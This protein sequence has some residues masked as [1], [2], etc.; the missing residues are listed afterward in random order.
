MEGADLPAKQTPQTT[1]SN[2]R[3]HAYVT[4]NNEESDNVDSFNQDSALAEAIA[5]SSDVT[6]GEVESIIEEAIRQMDPKQPESNPQ[7]TRASHGQPPSEGATPKSE[8]LKKR[9]QPEP[10]QVVV[11]TASNDKIQSTEPR[12]SGD[13]A[14]TTGER[15]IKRAKMANKI[16]DAYKVSKPKN[17]R[18]QI[19]DKPTRPRPEGFTPAQDPANSKS[20]LPTSTAPSKAGASNSAADAKIPRAPQATFR[21]LYEPALGLTH[22][23]V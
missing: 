13:K 16:S 15:V 4:S 9:K 21:N 1:L 7:E 10:I 23:A 8:Q 19:N 3:R 18:T 17:D 12:P 2:K 6:Q 11:E 5:A 20:L 14:S 22:A